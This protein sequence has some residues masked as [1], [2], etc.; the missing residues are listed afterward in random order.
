MLQVTHC[1]HDMPSPSINFMWVR[2]HLYGHNI[3]ILQTGSISFT[4][5]EVKYF[6]QAHQVRE[7]EK[8]TSLKAPTPHPHPPTF[9]IIYW[10]LFR[11]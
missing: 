11:F 1:E 7:Y 3:H 6:L 8:S 9:A 5:A 4:P 10:N 2:E